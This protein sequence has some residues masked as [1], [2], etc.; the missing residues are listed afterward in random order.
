MPSVSRPQIMSEMPI[1]T[2]L[3]RLVKPILTPMRFSPRA[4]RRRMEAAWMS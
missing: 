2:I 1:W 4:T 3:A